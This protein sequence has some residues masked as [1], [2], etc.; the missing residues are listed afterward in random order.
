MRSWHV[1]AIV[2]LLIAGV[3]AGGW[4]LSRSARVPSG[5][6]AQTAQSGD[7]RVTLHID[8]TMVGTRVIDVLVDDAEGQPADVSDVRLRI[9]MREMDMGQTEITAQP[10]GRGHFQAKGQFF[11]MVGTW[12]VEAV[13]LRADQQTT[14]VPFTLAIAAPG[15]QSGPINPIGASPEASQAGQKLYVTNCVPCHGSTGKGDGPSAA[16]L[17]PRPADFTLHMSPGMHTDGQIFLWI[18][19]GFPNSAM[20]AW[21]DR[22]SEE[23]IWQ[24]VSYLR[25]FN[26]TSTAANAPLVTYLP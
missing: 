12:G 2:A 5:G 23:Q 9:A 8:D 16:G 22:L 14:Q 18:K 26:P 13:L 25:T 21:S 19:N 15:E 11:S 20:P 6:V 1:F 7:L 17:N 3:A 24:L 10:V 4:L